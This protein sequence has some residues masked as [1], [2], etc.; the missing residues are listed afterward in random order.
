MSGTRVNIWKQ[1]PSVLSLGIRPA[2]IPNT[3][4]KV[5]K[6][7]RDAKIIMKGLPPVLPNE[8]GDFLLYPADDSIAFDMV[9]TYAVVRQTLNMYFRGLRRLGSKS[10]FKWQWGNAA[11][12][13]YPRAGIDANAYYNRSEKSLKFFH[14]PSEFHD[15]RMVYTC[16][17]FDIV[18]HEAG[19]AI[20]DALQPGYFHSWHP[21][22]GGLHESFGDLTAIFTMLSQMDMCEAI[23]SVSKLNL[24]A[25]SF[26]TSLAEEFGEA[27][28]GRDTGLR[29]ANNDLTMSDV[30]TQVHDISRV[31]T[32]AVYDILADIFE[33]H[34]DLEQ[35]NPAETLFRVGR[36][37]LSF[38]IEAIRKGP[39]YEATFI[40][41]AELM[42]LTMD[43]FPAWQDIARQRFEERLILGSSMTRSIERP[44][45]LDRSKCCGTMR[46]NEYQKLFSRSLKRALR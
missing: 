15:G 23:I 21:E 45:E 7:P 6:G 37:M 16:R 39:A 26:F 40:D 11:L 5:R 28:Y 13:I 12:R 31:F 1:D 14:F 22:T 30:T 10:A 36:Y 42:I 2:F 8:N 33:E 19:H 17:S 4:Y 41:I 38:L 18:A 3:P 25:E 46:G 27:L 43:G 24:H 20:L 32:G 44:Q 9:H 35:Y 34:L 29:N